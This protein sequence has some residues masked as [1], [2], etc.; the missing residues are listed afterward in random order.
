MKGL[1]HGTFEIDGIEG[2]GRKMND[3]SLE[4]FDFRESFV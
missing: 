3:C 4:K 2:S 1:S